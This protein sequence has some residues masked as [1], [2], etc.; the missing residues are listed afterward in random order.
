MS[1]IVDKTGSFLYTSNSGGSIYAYSIGSGGALS[2]QTIYTPNGRLYD[3]VIDPTGKFLYIAD[4]GDTSNGS[5]PGYVIGFSINTSTGALTLINKIQAGTG[6]M[7]V[8]LD[9]SGQFIYA[10]NSNSANVS[11]YSINASTGVLSS[12]GTY[13]A[14]GGPWSIVTVQK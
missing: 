8:A 1:G 12:I 5:D 11:G 2:N 10:A 9:P 3:M 7:S 14:G 4:N 13:S 6:T